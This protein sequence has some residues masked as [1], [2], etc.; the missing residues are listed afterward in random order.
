MNLFKRSKWRKVIVHLGAIEWEELN[1]VAWDMVDRF[2]VEQNKPSLY[3]ARYSEPPA[4]DS[5]VEIQTRWDGD[6]EELVG[7]FSNIE[8]VTGV[9]LASTDGS[10]PHTAAYLLARHL[11]GQGEALTKDTLHW[12]LNMTGYSYTG[13]IRVLAE[14]VATMA[15]NQ[16]RSSIR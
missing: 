11:R 16:E 5:R 7:W 2:W 6:P 9:G 3:F 10:E 13:E 12:A 4:G 15:A 1:V 8:G 14:Q